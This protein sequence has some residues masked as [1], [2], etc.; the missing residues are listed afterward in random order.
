MAATQ[1][2]KTK[3][4][5]R[6]LDD[7]FHLNNESDNGVISVEIEKLTPFSGHPFS[8]YEGERF[9]DMVESIK[10]NGVLV[11]VIA[12]RI[13]E[14]IEILAGHNRVNAAKLAGL[15]TV[16]T[17]VMENVTADE[18][19]VY[20]IETNL[21]QRSF[22]DMAH[23]EKAAVIALHHSKIFSQGKRSDIL[24]QLQML[25]NP[26]EFKENETYSQVANKRKS[27]YK[28]GQDYNLSKDTVARYLRIQRLI[29]ALKSRLD[30]GDIAFI[31]AVTLSYLKEDEQALVNDC[32]E[33]NR[34]PVGM[35]KA[36]ALRQFSKN[37][38]LNGES[39]YLILKGETAPKPG[40]PSTVK[41]NRDVYTKYFQ[42]DQ[43]TK[44]VQEIVEE[45]LRMYFEKP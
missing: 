43:P 29:T 41:I 16:P 27:I 32:M 40:R 28:V 45:A 18:A 35:K 34:L 36:D 22:S 39:V 31:P 5:L 7:L 33:R 13:A 37:G 12:R 10:S 17:I 24:K 8:L 44:E 14:T 2:K 15:D 19:M 23:S 11:P 30:N 26:H 4:H 9:D 42:P 21:M 3:P 38:K 6:N 25:D 20:V 1:A